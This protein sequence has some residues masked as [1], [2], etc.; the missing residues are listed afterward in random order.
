[1]AVAE[2][3]VVQGCAM[4]S[5]GSATLEFVWAAGAWERRKRSVPPDLSELVGDSD[6]PN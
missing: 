5:C 1:M 3:H 6:S 4:F 2:L